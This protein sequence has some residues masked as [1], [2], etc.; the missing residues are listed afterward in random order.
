MSVAGPLLWHQW[1]IIRILILDFL[2][3]PE[4]RSAFAD[5]YRWWDKGLE[6]A[7]LPHEEGLSPGVQ[8]WSGW[9]RAQLAP[10]GEAYNYAIASPLAARTLAE[11]QSQQLSAEHHYGL[12]SVALSRESGSALVQH[13]FAL[14]ASRV[15]LLEESRLAYERAISLD[16]E[17]ND[18]VE[19]LALL[20]DPATGIELLR[21]LIE[22][23]TEAT[24]GPNAFINLTLLALNEGKPET[25][26]RYGE[27]GTELYPSSGRLWF[28]LGRAYENTKQT[29][30][31]VNSYRRSLGAG[32][33]LP[34]V[35]I[36]LV[37]ALT[38]LSEVEFEAGR[39]SNSLQLDDEA[40][41]VSARGY[42]H[43]PEDPLVVFNH[44]VAVAN[45]AL[46]ENGSGEQALDLLLQAESL[47]AQNARVIL[48]AFGN[49][50]LEK[51]LEPDV[52]ERID[53]HLDGS[54]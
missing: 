43:Y 25:A 8:D 45:A 24:P 9:V 27:R 28:N 52:V 10:P 22:L 19:N 12:W 7:G 54:D 38:Q 53:K 36:N 48:R 23:E 14:S 32:L 26:I 50:L 31:S 41:E 44:G 47:G 34:R 37:G 5:S 30:A 29:E 35:Y 46:S 17:L 13:N 11:R 20:M 18:S 39:V 1:N 42:S 4:S 16:P 2:P 33:D 49:G 21:S 40:L 3:D 51:R 6:P 15:G